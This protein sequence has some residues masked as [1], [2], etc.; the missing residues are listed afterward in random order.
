MSSERVAGVLT[1]FRIALAIL[2]VAAATIVGA[3][4]FQALGYAPCELCLKERIPYYVGIA[5]AALTLALAGAS[6]KN[7]TAAAFAGLFL[8]FS[9][10]TVFGVYHSG[11]EFG[12]WPGPTD[13]TGT[14]DHAGS[15]GDFMKQLQTVKVVRCDV[16][17][18]RVLGVS[19]AVWNA[20]ISAFLAALAALA[21][22]LTLRRPAAPARAASPSRS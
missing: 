18:L 22:A 16:V 5:L 20:A 17:S 4:I 14:L 9:A 19:L 15:V 2:I 8:I 1:P 10:G 7:W 21:L 6:Q 3:W 13:C 11:V 12:F